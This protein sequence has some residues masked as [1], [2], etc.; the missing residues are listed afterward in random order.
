MK[1]KEGV[2]VVV[3]VVVLHVCVQ[4]VLLVYPFDFF[5]KVF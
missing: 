2:W 3:V 1:I 5:D 4:Y